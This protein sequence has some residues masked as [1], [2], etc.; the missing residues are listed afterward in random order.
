MIREVAE[1][2][3]SLTAVGIGIRITPMIW[4][5]RK[6]IAGAIRGWLREG[7]RSD[8][9][10]GNGSIHDGLEE[11]KGIVIRHHTTTSQVLADH[12]ARIT[13]GGNQIDALRETVE[14]NTKKLDALHTRVDVMA[15]A[16]ADHIREEEPLKE[17]F[18]KILTER[19]VEG[20]GTLRGLGRLVPREATIQ[21]ENKE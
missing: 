16:F 19:D 15:A 20:D 1:W 9:R 13:S 4:R 2:A 11:L 18:E 8:P 21:P 12:G 5:N 17:K 14:D 10:Q 6:R 3:A 7:E